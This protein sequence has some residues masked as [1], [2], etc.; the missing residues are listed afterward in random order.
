MGIGL[1]GGNH[2][3]ADV[4]VAMAGKIIVPECRA[5]DLGKI[6]PSATTENT[7]CT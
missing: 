6:A 3:E 7:E 1:H 4:E 5:A 2:T